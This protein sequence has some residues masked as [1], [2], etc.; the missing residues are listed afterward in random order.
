MLHLVYIQR[1]KTREKKI[2][3]RERE[4]KKEFKLREVSKFEPGGSEKQKNNKERKKEK[5][6]EKKKK[7]QERTKK[8]PLPSFLLFIVGFA[9]FF[10]IQNANDKYVTIHAC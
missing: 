8:N 7:F 10:T 2:Q 5:T 9:F 3:V 4:K 6:R 1:E